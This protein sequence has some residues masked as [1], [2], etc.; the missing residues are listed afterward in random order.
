MASPPPKLTPAEAADWWEALPPV[1][2]KNRIGDYLRWQ[3][4]HGKRLLHFAHYM[5]VAYYGFH[6]RE[7]TIQKRLVPLR[8]LLERIGRTLP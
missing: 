3:A 8:P 4:S 6:P 7:G 2:I 1:E 5:R